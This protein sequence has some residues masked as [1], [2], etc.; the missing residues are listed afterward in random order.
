MA[1]D[2]TPPTSQDR[3]M[4]S[5]RSIIRSTLPQLTYAIAWEYVITATDGTTVDITPT[6]TTTPVA[7]LEKVPI[8]PSIAGEGVILSA[9]GLNACVG[10]RCV[11]IFLNADPAKPVIVSIETPAGALPAA[12]LGDAA[13]P[14]VITTASQN[15]RIP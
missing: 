10:L 1:D 2:L 13:G 4:A 5:L 11:V 9:A 6:D 12:R 14:F 8:R 3:M 15:V 7:A